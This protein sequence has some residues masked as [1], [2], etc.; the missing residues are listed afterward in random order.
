[1]NLLV[2]ALLLWVLPMFIAYKQGVA[3]HRL[4]L[5]Y[6]LCLGWIGVIILALLPAAEPYRA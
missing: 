2:L 1:M 6:G 3:K 4:G 5:A